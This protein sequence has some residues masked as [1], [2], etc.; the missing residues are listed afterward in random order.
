MTKPWRIHDEVEAEVAETVAWYENARPEL[1]FDFL[2]ELRRTLADL[3]EWPGTG[4]P[5]PDAPREARVR[6]RRVGRFKHAVVYAE[7]DTEYVVIA[8]PH[9][10]R[11]P[12][13]WL[14]RLVEE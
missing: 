10:A 11:E 2:S 13:Y 3:R 1:G 9:L 8:V 12:G 5:D 6:R 4:S 14:H 7:S